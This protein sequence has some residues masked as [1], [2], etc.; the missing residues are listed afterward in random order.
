MRGVVRCFAV[1]GL[2]IASCSG[3][4]KDEVT[5]PPAPATARDPAP[6]S[7]TPAPVEQ[8]R[9]VV[10]ITDEA[11]RPGPK[12]DIDQIH[13][14]LVRVRFN[15]DVPIGQEMA[16]EIYLPGGALYQIYRRPVESS[17]VVFVVP[18]AGTDITKHRLLGSFGLV[19]SLPGEGPIHTA[20]LELYEKEEE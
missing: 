19:V 3:E 7:A 5:Q 15:R 20:G 9:A 12:H 11:D 10:T 6:P 16:L 18:V 8:P 17:D 13:D 4:K 14:L 2:A 1:L